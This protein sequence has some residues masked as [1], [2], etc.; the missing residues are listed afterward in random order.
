MGSVQLTEKLDSNHLLL[1]AILPSVFGLT[2]HNSTRQDT[3]AKYH[4]GTCL[5][6]KSI[7]FLTVLYM[8]Y[9]LFEK[10]SGVQLTC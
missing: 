7:I 10:S 1:I 6:Q 8:F 4:L 5:A 9:T 2:W 3:V